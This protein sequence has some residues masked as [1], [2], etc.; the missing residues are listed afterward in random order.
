MANLTPVAATKQQA[1]RLRSVTSMNICLNIHTLYNGILCVCVCVCV[2][3]CDNISG[4]E[5]ALIN[6]SGQEVSVAKTVHG[7]S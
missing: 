6:W 3:L 5:E 4:T 1:L 2:C 7:C